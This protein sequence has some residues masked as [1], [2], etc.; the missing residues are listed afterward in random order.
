M[1]DRDL[2][3]IADLVRNGFDVVTLLREVNEVLVKAVPHYW[4]PCWYT[5]DPA[6]QLI[7]SH[8]HEGLDEFPAEWLADEYSGDDVHSLNVVIATGLPVSTLHEITGGDPSGSRRW[9]LNMELGGDQELIAPLRNRGGQVWGAL[10]L[11]REPGAPVFSAGERDDIIRMA[12]LL[13]DGIRRGLLMGEAIDPEVSTAPGLVIL[14]GPTEVASMTDRAWVLLED[15]PDGDLDRGLLPTAISSVAVAAMTKEGGPGALPELHLRTRSGSWVTLH[16]SVLSSHS[17]HQAAVIIEPEHPSRIIPLLMD[18]YGLTDREQ[19][20]TRLV[21][22]GL[23]TDRIAKELLV[24]P[25]TI[26][27]H[28]KSIFDKTGVR[29]RSALIGQV[30]FRHYEPRLRDNESRVATARPVRGGP[31]QTG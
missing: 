6:S 24:V 25:A 11:Y 8:F 5:M 2:A 28:L 16:G 19:Q 17:G 4:T 20:V 1:T 14:D 13:A 30:F 29:S 26:Q 7:T 10:G 9:K 15:F 3:K 21:L 18:A 27:Q 31:S 12:P 23:S 22:A